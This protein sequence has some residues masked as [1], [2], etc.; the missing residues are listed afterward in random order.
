[1]TYDQ[2]LVTARLLNGAVL[3]TVTG[4]EFS[5]GVYMECPFF[6]P[7]ST[8]LGRSDGKLAAERFV[9]RYNEIRSHRPVD[10]QDVSRNSSY[11]VILAQQF[12]LQERS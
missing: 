5:V 2:M 8:G 6:I 10:Y 12:E 7:L 3:R 1:M 4:K 11:F 9:D